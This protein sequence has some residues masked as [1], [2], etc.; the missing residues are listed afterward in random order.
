MNAEH[1]KH[2]YTVIKVA[3]ELGITAVV[4][5]RWDLHFEV[6]F[7]IVSW[8]LSKFIKE[9]KHINHMSRDKTVFMRMVCKAQNKTSV[10]VEGGPEIMS[11][12]ILEF[13]RTMCRENSYHTEEMLFPKIV[14]QFG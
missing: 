4:Y 3:S 7:E 9:H 6:W 11:L 10:Q 1:I 2:G 8:L 14:F 13:E 12:M 5:G